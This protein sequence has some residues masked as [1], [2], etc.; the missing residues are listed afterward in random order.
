MVVRLPCGVFSLG[1][2]VY[3][4]MSEKTHMQKDLLKILFK[5]SFTF[6]KCLFLILFATTS[7]AADRYWVGGT[8][9]W[10]ASTTTHWSSS[11][12]GASGASVPTST[13]NVYIDGSSGGGT[14]TITAT[15]NCL[16][17]TWSATSGA[18][19]GSS[20]LYVY[21]SYTLNSGMTLS[22]S[23]SVYFKATSTGKT[24]TTA[25][26]SISGYI[27]FDGSGGGWTFQDNFTTSSYYFMCYAGTVNTNGYT[28]TLS[29]SYAEI[30]I[31]G[32][33]LTLGASIVNFSHSSAEDIYI[34][35]GTLNCNSAIITNNGSSSG[36]LITGGTVNL[37]SSTITTR[38]LYVSGGTIDFGTSTITLTGATSNTTYYELYLA[39][40][41]TVTT[42]T[43]SITFTGTN[44]SETNPIDVN[45]GTKTVYDLSF[46]SGTNKIN[47]NDGGTARNVTFASTSWINFESTKTFTFTGIVSTTTTCETYTLFFS[48]TPASASTINLS[49]TQTAMSFIQ[50]RDIT[51]SGTN[52]TCTSCVNA[53][54]NSGF[55]F[56][57]PYIPQ[58]L[59]WRGTGTGT[60]NWGT[61]TNWTENADGTLGANTCVPTI[62]DAVVFDANSFDA[63]G[64]T[65]T[66]NQRA[67]AASINFTGTTNSPAF[68][69]GGSYEII[70]S[71][72]LTLTSGIGTITNSGA[73]YLIGST[74]QLLTCGGKKLSTGTTY[75]SNPSTIYLQDDGYFGTVK[76]MKGTLDV[77]NQAGST[78]YD[79]YFSQDWYN[80]ATFQPRTS[81]SNYVVFHGTGSGGLYTTPTFYNFKTNSTSTSATIW[82]E[83]N[84]TINNE[85][86][87]TGG[88]YRSGNSNNTTVNGS[89]NVTSTTTT[90]YLYNSTGTFTYSNN[91]TTNFN[92]A[93]GEV[94]AYSTMN[95]GV[96]GTHSTT[97]LNIGNASGSANEAYFYNTG[98]L[99]VADRIVAYSDGL[100]QVA[101]GTINI[102]T[103]TADGGT[104]GTAKW[105]M[106]AS[107]QF[108]M[109]SG[110]I[111][112]LGSADNNTTNAISFSTSS[113]FTAANIT[114]GT[115]VLQ[116]TTSTYNYPVD[117]GGKT[118]Y[119]LTVNTA[120]RTFKQVTNAVILKGTFTISAGTYDANGLA[121]SVAANWIN[122]SGTYTHNNATVTFN[123]TSTLTTGGNGAGKAFYNVILNGTSATLA[124]N[125]DIDNSFTL[126]AG[127]WDVS[128]SNYS[129]NIGGNWSNSG[130]FTPRSGT[131]VFDGTSTITTGGTG[132]GKIFYNVTLNGT[133]G[134]LSGNID[135]DNHFTMTAGTWDVS[136]SNYSMNIG[137]D[138]VNYGGTFT[139]QAGT[140]TFDGSSTQYINVTSSGG[141]TP[142][143]ADITFYNLIINGS[144]VKMYYNS[145]NSRVINTNDFTVNSGKQ[146]SVLGI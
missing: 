92:L 84:V 88:V 116:S 70:V 98:T 36:L 146:C 43:P 50:V 141:T 138:F 41:V 32:G 20:S 130:T 135:I 103:Y 142:R 76:I 144:D 104:A 131:V 35:S 63:A 125:I 1:Y 136:A 87:I 14:I 58:T 48:S 83:S 145:S 89:V 121:M 73:V 68:T 11:S 123:G 45:L 99:N 126:T 94:W 19:A 109:S 30:Y 33:T 108:K 85:L 47:F 90:G 28:L 81:A 65:V 96:T 53:G 66:L 77:Q 39:S 42:G 12:G 124:G 10:D 93:K 15:A 60:G 67:T 18:L 132:A 106:Q 80:Y 64:K 115:V 44:N 62:V 52:T 55:T 129:M 86:L 49:A 29:S 105:E 100:F 26:K 3:D 23:G 71:G 54:T 112:V 17:F 114:G 82:T 6:F 79:L 40:G 2:S 113:T 16:D 57:S 7:F 34:T 134:T 37:G 128:A 22:H 5:E 56:A 111:N 101:G 9:N 27:Y 38:G 140:V 31:A 102:K 72:N 69:N 4:W 122:S 8:G 118:L 97:V 78:V 91:S 119:N 13:D 21:G 139:C 133:A 127:T 107:S 51:N 120:S 25:G 143:N 61:G 137:G 74:A 59:Y 95:I 117:F 46:T 24:V 75:F 110:T